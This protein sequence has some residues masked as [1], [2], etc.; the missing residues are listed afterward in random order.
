MASDQI[1]S[2]LVFVI[3]A[4]LLTKHDIGTFAIA[5]IFSEL[6]RIVST[7]GT[8][9]NVARARDMTPELK[10]TVFWTNVAIALAVAVV[11]LLFARPFATLIHQPE[12]GP[13][14]QALACVPTV[15][16]LGATHLALRLREFGHKTMAWRSLFGGIVGGGAAVVAAFM[17]FG[18]WSLVVQRAATELANTVTAW[19]AFR[20]IPGFRFSF[21]RLK[22]VGRFGINLTLTQ[23][24]VL[25][26]V[27]VQDLIIGMTLGAAA[28][29]TYRTAWRTTELIN[30]AGIQPFTT[31]ALQTLSRLQDDPDG[32]RRAYQWMI[33]TSSLICFP[34]L[35][36]FGV[37]APEAIPA[38]YGAKWIEAGQL[39]Q[40]FAFMVVPFCLNFFA[41]PVLTALGRG[42][43]IRTL[44]MVQLTLTVALTWVAAPHGIFAVAYAYVF[45][46]YLTLP[47]QIWYLR[48]S[49]GIGLRHTVEAVEM[50]FLASALMGACVW[51]IMSVCRNYVPDRVQLLTIGVTS[52]VVIYGCFLLVFSERVRSAAKRIAF[53]IFKPRLTN[54]AK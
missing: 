23:I 16:A 28:V 30:S 31:V 18:I 14:L 29:G 20:W 4:R 36:G 33:S 38:I 45:R 25:M 9:Q 44:A 46:A 2:F 13:I 27:R 43:N 41:G 11:G 39:A 32:M 51:A 7:G 47:L 10:D 22:Q 12:A 15:S 42:S 8:T 40:I 3:L 54:L 17:G 34:A 5:L 24:I 19:H 52:G 37:V 53:R 50:P 49:A 6:G 21:I 1:F 35:V 26:L 48:R